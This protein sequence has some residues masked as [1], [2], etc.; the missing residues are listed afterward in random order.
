[1]VPSNCYH[2][3]LVLMIDATGAAST[4]L[5]DEIHMWRVSQSTDLAL[6]TQ[7][8]GGNTPTL[9]ANY[10]GGGTVPTKWVKVQADD[11]T[12]VLVPGWPT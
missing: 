3:A 6:Q 8:L 12:T 2:I 4:I 9:G 11:G 7:A 10:P 1:V 5:F